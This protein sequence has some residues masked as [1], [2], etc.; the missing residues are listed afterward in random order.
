MMV[1]QK[2]QRFGFLV[3]FNGMQTSLNLQVQFIEAGIGGG[4][5]KL[6]QEH[7]QANVASAA[8]L[9]TTYALL[10]LHSLRKKSEAQYKMT[11]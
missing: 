9:T 2:E 8:K 6:G 10:V 3:I 7:E 1:G 11:R 4:Q 5:F